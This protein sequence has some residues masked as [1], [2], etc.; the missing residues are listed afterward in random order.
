MQDLAL[1]NVNVESVWLNSIANYVKSQIMGYL[2]SPTSIV[3]IL[4]DL[5]AIRCGIAQKAILGSRKKGTTIN[6]VPDTPLSHI[7]IFPGKT[8]AIVWSLPEAKNSL[9]TLFYARQWN[10]QTF[11]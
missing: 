9:K 6:S 11:K 4:I 2:I 10:I 7:Y 1:G 8:F 5:L 3:W